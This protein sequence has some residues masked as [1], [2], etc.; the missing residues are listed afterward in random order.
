M[1]FL[2]A[3]EV[4]YDDALCKSTFTLRYFTYFAAATTLSGYSFKIFM[5]ITMMIGDV[6]DDLCWGRACNTT[7]YEECRMVGSVARCSCKV[8]C[9]RIVKP[10]CASDRLTYDSLC[11]LQRHACLTRQPLLVRYFGTCGQ[12]ST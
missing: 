5:M 3:L 12:C 1:P 6:A 8:P 7:L 2:S 10:V 11:H 4:V 9:E